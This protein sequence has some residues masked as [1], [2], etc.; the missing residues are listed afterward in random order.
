[1]KKYILILFIA[2]ITTNLTFATGPSYIDSI[3]NPIAIN[4][5]GDVLCR[6]LYVENQMGGYGYMDQY[7]GL[8]ILTKDSI[9]EYPVFNL[10]REYYESVLGRDQDTYYDL[11]S[12][13]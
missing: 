1:M 9:I 8:C 3:I 5:N 6:T 7:Y 11:Y 12:L 13:E 2:I 4:D 10:D